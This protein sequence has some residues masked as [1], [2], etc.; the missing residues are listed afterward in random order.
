M[1]CLELQRLREEADAAAAELQAIAALLSDAQLTWRAAP[2]KWSIADIL[3]HLSI[4]TEHCLPAVDRAIDEAHGSGMQAQ[5][6]FKLT[7]MGRFFVW[8][9]E[10]P[11][12]IKLPAPKK[13]VPVLT[14]SPAAALPTFLHSQQQM[15]GRL[16]R[17][18]GLDLNRARF[19][20]PFAAFITM[21]ML[22]FFS[23]FASH[24][25]RHIWQARN[26][27]AAMPA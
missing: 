15:M 9:V 11:P 7:M 22:A 10:P 18:N 12:A 14:G 27:V 5:G 2:G 3:I 23:V 1:L 4:T 20:S 21:D 24:E 8:Y 6:P 13:L 19:R 25:R 17:A 26:V 16:E